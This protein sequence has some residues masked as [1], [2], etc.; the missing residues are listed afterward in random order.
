MSKL[1]LILLPLALMFA[2]TPPAAAT[3]D[4]TT[5]FESRYTLK[6]D[7]TTLVAH[8]VTLTNNLAHLYTTEY[9]MSLGGSDL[10][11]LRATDGI[12]DLPLST[13]T[14]GNTTTATVTLVSPQIGQGKTNTI[15]ISYESNEVATRI[16]NNWE[17]SIPRVARANEYRE[18]RRLV[19]IPRALGQATYTYP[20]PTHVDRGD[21]TT[22][23][24]LGF[25]SSSLTLLFGKEQSYHLNL[26]YSVENPSLSSADTEIALPPETAYQHVLLAGINPEPE[27]I[28]LDQDGNWMA[29]YPLK[30]KETKVIQ[31][32]MYLSITPLP[33][34]VRLPP[35]SLSLASDPNWQ[36]EDPLVKD[37]STRLTSP[38]QIYD[39]L[40]DNFIYDYSRVGGD[41]LGAKGALGAPAKATCTEFT[42][43]FI[44]LARSRGIRAREV[45][46]YAYGNRIDS[47]PQGKDILHAWPEYFDEEQKVWIQ[48][49]PTWG[50]TTGGVDYFDKLDFSHLTFVIH[51]AE[52]T[53]PLPA[54]SYKRSS[55]ATTIEVTPVDTIPAR[56]T[57]SALTPHLEL[58]VESLAPPTLWSR[59]LAFIQGLF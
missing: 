24:Y 3:G 32:E 34:Q 22:Y 35:G 25:P 28:H 56:V 8:T 23:T 43:A 13:H 10:K 49:D 11:G 21:F 42:D 39:Y 48:V 6:E 18:Y 47:R 57:P 53:Y 7:G 14:D 36:T 17:L 12:H 59:L 30:A 16:G 29:V 41:R 46:G 52:S 2:L 31:V 9:S 4:F 40:V 20:E 1:L 26:T 37:L 5:D 54:G 55:D 58:P 27:S 19:V 50:S 15:A 45:N 33:R 44:A 51:G 38:R